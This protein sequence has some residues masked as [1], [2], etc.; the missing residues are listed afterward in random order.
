MVDIIPQTRPFRTAESIDA[1]K[2]TRDAVGPYLEALGFAVVD[3][4]THH[5]T[6]QS[7][8]IAASKDGLGFTAR[9][10]IC[11][12][13]ED[14]RAGGAKY[15]AAQL[16]AK[17]KNGDWG[18]TLRSISDREK[19]AGNSHNLFIQSDGGQLVHAALVPSDQLPAIW[20]RQREVYASL[21]ASGRAGKATRNAVENGQSPTLYLQDDRTSDTPEVAKIL[22]TWPGVLNL[23][24]LQNAPDALAEQ[25]DTFDDLPIEP[26]AFGRDGGDRYT[27][28]KSG[29]RRDAKVRQEVLRRS[30]GVCEK[31]DCHATRAFKGFLDVHHILGIYSSDRVWSCVALCPN[32]HR[33]AHFADDRD[34]INAALQRYA[35]QFRPA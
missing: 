14:R 6:A 22:W 12:N 33:D 26:N 15:A 31:E 32:C 2:A 18:E 30:N 10:K 34:A 20:Q 25:S 8:T 28:I 17:L 27:T 13:R 5:G 1:E 35:S 21:I 11:W 16:A 29:F 7:Q 3:T 23:N 24:A 9:V 19:S 4:R